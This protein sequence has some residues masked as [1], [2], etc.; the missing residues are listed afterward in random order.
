MQEFK[1]LNIKFKDNESEPSMAC[2]ASGGVTMKAPVFSRFV[3]SRV[4]S[5]A[6]APAA[7]DPT[8]RLLPFSTIGGRFLSHLRCTGLRSP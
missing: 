2:A 5:L 8:D 3:S 7:R 1:D 4:L 6:S